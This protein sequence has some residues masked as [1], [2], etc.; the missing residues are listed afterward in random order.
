[1]IKTHEGEGEGDD[2]GE[3]QADFESRSTAKQ[4]CEIYGILLPLHA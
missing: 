3:G 1:M 4:A 2:D